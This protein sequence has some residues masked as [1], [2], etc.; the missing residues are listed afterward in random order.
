M[1]LGAAG[2][3]AQP[4]RTHGR[5]VS[6]V[7]Y[8]SHNATLAAL[9]ATCE[10]PN[11]LM[12]LQGPPLAG[13][14]T[15]IRLFVDTLSTERCTAVLDGKD[16]NTT[17]L[18][19][20]VLRQ[21]GYV[22]EHNSNNE[23]MGM[24][25]VF[26]LHQ[27]A[28]H[29]SPVLIIENTH[30]L[31]PSALRV[32]CE[33]A[34]LEV[35]GAAAVKIVL[36]SDRSLRALLDSPSMASLANRVSCDMHLR[37]MNGIET[38]RYLHGKLRAAGS[39]LPERVFPETVCTEFWRAS[40]G[41]PGILDRLALLCLAKASNLPVNPANIERPLLPRGTWTDAV[42]EE[43]ASPADSGPQSPTL[44]I[45]RNGETL[46]EIKFTR[47]RMLVGRSEHNDV[48]IPSNYVSRH[49]ALLVRHRNATLLMDLNSTNGTYVNSRRVSNHVL[50][51]D[52]VITLGHH[53]IKFHDPQATTRTALEGIDF[54]D[55][56]IMKNLEDVRRLLAQENTEVLPAIPE[57]QPVPG[58]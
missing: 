36:S 6:I 2:L 58:H 22:I 12:L 8:E 24:L 29:E 35:R 19:E 52:D 30:S 4:F 47:D 7:P 55:T 20:S 31:N 27:C 25:R 5:P 16:L 54:T 51:H 40:G 21:Y 38:A 57:K 32:L 13:K 17:G 9:K 37:P 26:A 39:R 18:L 11:G 14:T 49:H 42:D 41:W 53:R 23:L 44:F 45:S 10:A 48:E 28:A 43:A 15:L 3:N 33:L 34:D 56:A 50:V 46:H 1:D